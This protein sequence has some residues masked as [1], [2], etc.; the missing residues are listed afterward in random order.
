M[1]YVISIT[2]SFYSPIKPPSH[3]EVGWPWRC[4]GQWRL[5]HR[6]LAAHR[7][8][9]AVIILR[10]TW[11]NP[12]AKLRKID[13]KHGKNEGTDRNIQGKHGK[14]DENMRNTGENIDGQFRENVGK[15][16]EHMQK[17]EGKCW[18]NIGDH[19]GN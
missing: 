1:G 5:H 3:Q 9:W 10:K 6:G 19:R 13:E 12:W 4:G 16:K 15:L 14:N 2:S 7:G 18:E 17:F 11:E 8:T